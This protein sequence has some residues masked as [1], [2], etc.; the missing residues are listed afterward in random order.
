MHAF[1]RLDV[2]GPFY[3][4]NLS[5]E[6]DF[7]RVLHPNQI[8]DWILIEDENLNNEASVQ[9]RNDLNNSAANMTFA[10]SFQHHTMRNERAPLYHLIKMQ[11]IVTCVL[12]NLSSK[13]I[14]FIL[15]LS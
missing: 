4:K 2:E 14:L 10:L 9:F 13:A 7:E 5:K 8:L 11:M 6:D 3:F 12:N 1:D 15:V